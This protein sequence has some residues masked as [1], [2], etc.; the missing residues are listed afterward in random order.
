MDK[1]FSEIEQEEG[2]EAVV[3]IWQHDYAIRGYNALEYIQSY[4]GFSEE[5]LRKAG[6]SLPHISDRNLS[7]RRLLQIA[8]LLHYLGSDSLERLDIGPWLEECAVAGYKMTNEQRCEFSVYQLETKDLSPRSYEKTY[9]DTP[10]EVKDGVFKTFNFFLDTPAAIGLFHNNEPRAV[11][12]FFPEDEKTLQIKQIQG[13]RIVTKRK[14]NRN[15]VGYAKSSNGG[16][17]LGNHDW[18]RFLV[19]CAEQVGKDL[20]YPTISIQGARNNMWVL[21]GALP[22][23]RGLQIYDDTAE[24][25]GY[26]QE[27]IGNWYKTP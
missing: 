5:N 8:K 18:K 25:L 10:V 21:D 16:G 11:V 24:R 15:P 4:T 19:S 27:G 22:L 2:I 26:S 9:G 12:S 20:G 17:C 3:R 6:N 13:A 14:N 23:E 7:A 1:T